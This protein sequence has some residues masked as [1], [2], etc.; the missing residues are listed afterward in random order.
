L[1]K[2][3]S[4]IRDAI[5]ETELN[6]A[7]V[8]GLTIRLSHGVMLLPLESRGEAAPREIVERVLQ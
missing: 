6:R 3:I 7:T 2:Q 8:E 5:T 1:E 4:R